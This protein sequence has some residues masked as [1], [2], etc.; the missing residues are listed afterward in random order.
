VSIIKARETWYLFDDDKIEAI[1][2]A[3]IPKYYGDSNAG[4]AYVLYY[5]AADLDYTALGL[6]RKISERELSD[7]A[8]SKT[9]VD[10]AS[11]TSINESRTLASTEESIEYENGPSTSTS[12]VSYTPLP[13]PGLVQSVNSTSSI[14]LLPVRGQPSL[15]ALKLSP[16]SSIEPS[17]LSLTA[18][19]TPSGTSGR[20]FL[21]SLRNSPSLRKRPSSSSALE[22][23]SIPTELPPSVPIFPSSAGN[24]STERGWPTTTNNA[25]GHVPPVS[26]VEPLASLPPSIS[27]SP[28]T[29]TVAS[30]SAALK[31][32]KDKDRGL[33]WFKP[34]LKGSRS[35]KEKSST[36][37][38]SEKV[39]SMA[40]SGDNDNIP[41]WPTFS[42]DS[43]NI[44]GDIRLP[45]RIGRRASDA[46]L[47]S[48]H[49]QQPLSSSAMSHSNA[50]LRAVPEHKHSNPEL[51]TPHQVSQPDKRSILLTRRPATAGGTS[52]KEGSIDMGPPPPPLPMSPQL[53]LKIRPK[54][55]TAVLETT[56][57]PQS[58][59]PIAHE[60]KSSSSHGVQHSH[61]GEDFASDSYP[62]MLHG[63]PYVGANGTPNHNI[64]SE[65]NSSSISSFHP[66]PST[67][68]KRGSRKLSLSTV[69][70]G[71]GKKD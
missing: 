60:A 67:K 23:K 46:I 37:T 53:A 43:A 30:H 31:N 15:E 26:P 4:S 8:A 29:S 3:D 20:R 5:Q 2:E 59:E 38:T 57:D 16:A 33:P 62:H 21:D 18:L 1:K 64:N 52:N 63:P 54:R 69:I 45:K 28:S 61:D 44:I 32:D 34:N 48:S 19:S 55:S 6:R 35:E 14:S 10:P 7:I 56:E 50:A 11:V 25:I 51:T 13:P 17:H 40:G 65:T 47:A 36:S 39:S 24:N 68:V 58:F 27:A 22:S 9:H 66:P 49:I 41:S 70:R 42:S 71:F 12:L